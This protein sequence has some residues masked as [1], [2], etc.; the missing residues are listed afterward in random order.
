MQ[1]RYAC[2]FF[3][4]TAAVLRLGG[5]QLRDLTLAHQGRGIGPGRGIGKQ[6]LNITRPNLAIIDLIGRARTPV[7]APHHL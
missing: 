2:G 4:N 3:Q 1:A 6:E 5:N 7:D